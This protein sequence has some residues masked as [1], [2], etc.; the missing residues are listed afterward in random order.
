MMRPKSLGDLQ[1][2]IMDIVWRRNK[3]STRNIVSELKKTRNVAYTTVAT[4]LQ[5]LYHQGL[6]ERT[7]QG[8][9]YIYS[10]K[11]S[12]ES[13]SKKLAQSFLKKF[14]H[15]FGDVA[16]ASFVET[17]DSLPKGKKEYFLKLLDD[18]DKTK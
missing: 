3:C 8:L 12:K 13:Y 18:H 17:I 11:L 9:A 16:I 5:R 15:S 6:L 1:Q 14:I 10:P 7:Q 4:I 2:Q